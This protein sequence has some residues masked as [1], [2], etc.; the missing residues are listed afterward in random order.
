MGNSTNFPVFFPLFVSFTISQCFENN[1]SL[2]RLSQRDVYE[3][4]YSSLLLPWYTISFRW[5]FTGNSNLHFVSV[6][7]ISVLTSWEFGNEVEIASNRV[8]QVFHGEQRIEQYSLLIDVFDSCLFVIACRFFS[9][10]GLVHFIF[11]QY[12]RLRN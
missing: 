11:V 3:W 9:V 6:G 7:V 12:F 10:L 4:C 8:D 1:R 5:T 2:K